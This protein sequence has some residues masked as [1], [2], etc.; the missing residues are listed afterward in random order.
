MTEI[1]P[2]GN[3]F[4]LLSFGTGGELGIG[5]IGGELRGG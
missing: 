3:G 5:L 1:V 4:A 2:G